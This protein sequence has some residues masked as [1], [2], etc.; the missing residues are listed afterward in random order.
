MCNFRVGQKVVCVYVPWPELAF[1][2]SA[3]FGVKLPEANKIYTIRWIGTASDGL[4]YVRL[5]EIVNPVVGVEG[6]LRGECRFGVRRF[7][8]IVTRNTD[9]TIFKAMLTDQPERVG[10]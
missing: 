9:I 10:A 8:P 5:V 4:T 3:A 6:F 1:E 7:R 2:L